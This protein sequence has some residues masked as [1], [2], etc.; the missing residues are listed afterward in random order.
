MLNKLY[1]LN[2]IKYSKKNTNTN[3][4]V[5]YILDD[6]EIAIEL[7]NMQELGKEYSLYCGEKYIRCEKCGILFRSSSNN[8]KYC[9]NCGKYERINIKTIICSGCGKEFEA[10][11]DSVKSFRTKSCGCTQYEKRDWTRCIKGHLLDG[12]NLRI[13]KSNKRVC[14]TCEKLRQQSDK[15]KATK[16]KYGKD[17]KD[18]IKDLYLKRAFNISIEEYNKLF[19]NQ[20]GCCAICNKHQTEFK[21]SF[22]VDHCHKTIKVRG[23]LCSKCNIGIG[24]FNDNEELL[25]KAIEYIKNTKDGNRI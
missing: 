8:S 1:K 18:R 16:R 4:C 2:M 21:K 5:N 9:K 7:H 19:E 24:Q 3:V 10:R 15:S 25:R 17:K 14:R 23:L 20:N 22:A 6:D 12:D 13:S 11:K